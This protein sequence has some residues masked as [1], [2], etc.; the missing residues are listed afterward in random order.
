M[1]AKFKNLSFDIQSLLCA[2]ISSSQPIA[3]S[4]SAFDKVF[5]REK[6]N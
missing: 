5:F 6:R 4:D 2:F 1:D 3:F